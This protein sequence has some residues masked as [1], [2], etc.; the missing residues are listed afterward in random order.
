MLFWK[1][2]SSFDLNSRQRKILSL[3][4]DE[5]IEMTNRNYVAICK[6]SRE[7]AKRDLTDLVK[8]GL[9]QLGHKKGRSTS[10]RLLQAEMAALK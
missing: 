10:Y 1:K 4:L 6:T 2:F 8:L 3:L 7:S 9:L 5:N